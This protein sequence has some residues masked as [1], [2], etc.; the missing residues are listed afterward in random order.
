MNKL[1]FV[2][3]TPSIFLIKIKH[4][5]E[6]LKKNFKKNI[7][8]KHNDSTNKEK[9]PIET[10]FQKESHDRQNEPLREYLNIWNPNICPSLLSYGKMEEA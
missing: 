10:S 6:K 7:E 2:E 4:F 5:W 9:A 1:I 3:A 8:R